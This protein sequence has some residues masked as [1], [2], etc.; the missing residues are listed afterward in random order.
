M[1]LAVVASHP[2]QYYAPLYRELAKRCDLM[3]FFAHRATPVDQAKS[4]FGIG[5]DWDVDL[6]SGYAYALLQ[7]VAERPGLDR[8]V[9]CDTPEIGS[10]LRGEH[11][12]AVLV[13]GWHFKTYLQTML[14][15]K[16]LGLPLLVRGDSHVATPRPALKKAL[17]AVGYPLFLRLFD[18]A[19]YVGVRSR[20]YW[21]HYGYPRARLFFSPHCVDSGWFAA[22]ATAGARRDLR[23]QLGIAA[24]T[25]VALFAGKL[26]P[27]KR[28][29]DLVAAANR[30]K[31][32]GEE[33]EII[34]A[35]AGSL[36]AEMN[37]AAHATG[38]SIHALGFCNQTKMPPAYAAADVV[39]LPSDA[40]ETWGLV[41]NE[42][43]ACGRPVIL[44]DAVGA[45][46]DLAADA[47][48]GRV[49]P[50]GDIAAL[51]EALHAVLSSP[52]ALEK[53]AAKSRAYSLAAAADGIEAA[54]SM[55]AARA[56][57]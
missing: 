42:A 13:H 23:S 57:R 37:A 21:N 31:R 12:D 10:R 48:A 28:P 1:R 44:S 11:F 56:P 43:L 8:F 49:F 29:L 2:I 6:T 40:R 47:T 5:F 25:K 51:A 32:E 53:I 52:P 9:A 20:L 19:L 27:F 39:V 14:A 41:A 45:A 50:V 22:R 54:L 7:N 46:P 36:E 55:T 38:V 16:R 26:V 18:A 4:G 15:A 30:M 34:V 17:K 3:V 35:G 24:D 33:I